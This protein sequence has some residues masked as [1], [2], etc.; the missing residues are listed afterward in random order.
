MFFAG[1]AGWGLRL[2]EAREY[3]ELVAHLVDLLTGEDPALFG[4]PLHLEDEGV[5]ADLLTEEL[6][7]DRHLN[8]EELGEDLGRRG[9]P[10]GTVDPLGLLDEAHRLIEC[11]RP[12]AEI[13]VRGEN[14]RVEDGE[15]HCASPSEQLPYGAEVRRGGLP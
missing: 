14:G 5:L 2:R 10:Y 9:V 4:P 15:H 12:Q 6:P 11:H 8:T 13:S 1:V 3:L 7:V